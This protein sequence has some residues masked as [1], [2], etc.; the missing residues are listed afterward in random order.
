MTQNQLYHYLFQKM[1][2]Y[3]LEYNLKIIQEFYNIPLSQ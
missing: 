1:A 3:P 2:P